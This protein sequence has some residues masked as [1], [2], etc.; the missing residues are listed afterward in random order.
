MLCSHLVLLVGY[1]ETSFIVRNSWSPSVRDA[2]GVL[3]VPVACVADSRF[4][5][6]VRAP[7]QWGEDGYIRL[8]RFPSPAC[9]IDLAPS[10]GN[11]CKNGPPQIEVCGTCGMFADSTYP[12]A[13]K[14]PGLLLRK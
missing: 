13:M 10:D 8:T 4:V 14:A 9:G 7:A 6:F 12:I 2:S 11:G 5:C 3:D 1:D